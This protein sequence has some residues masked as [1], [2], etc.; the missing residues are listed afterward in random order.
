MLSGTRLGVG[1]A[2]TV[3]LV[4]EMYATQLGLGLWISRG[5]NAMEADLLAFITLFVAATGALLI[6][7]V[8]Y[9]DQYFAKWRG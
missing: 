2:L 6:G 7:A 4:G 8:N 1:R 3:V 9:V 5:Q